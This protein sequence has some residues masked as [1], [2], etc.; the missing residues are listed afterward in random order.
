V[1]PFW[2]KP[3]RHGWLLDGGLPPPWAV[4][5]VWASMSEEGGR[6]RSG[7][8]L[9]EQLRV[10]AVKFRPPGGILQQLV[11]EVHLLKPLGRESWI[12]V[13][14][15]LHGQSSKGAFDLLFL[16]AGRNL[17]HRIMIHELTIEKKSTLGALVQRQAGLGKT[18]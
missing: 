8:G 16:G 5:R 2:R 6:R 11:G 10:E 9:R 13:R 17:E 15:G 1:P 3:Q 4:A 7:P 14:M 12:P 18:G